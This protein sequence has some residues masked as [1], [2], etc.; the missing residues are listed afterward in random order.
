MFGENSPPLSYTG[1]HAHTCS[2][3]T[4]PPLTILPCTSYHSNGHHHSNLI[5]THTNNLWV[6]IASHSYLLSIRQLAILTPPTT[7]FPN[8]LL[9]IPDAPVTTL[10]SHY[11][12]SGIKANLPVSSVACIENS[13][14]AL[15]ICSPNH[16]QAFCRIKSYFL[17]LTCEE[18][19]SGPC[20]FHICPWPSPQASSVALPPSSL[21]LPRFISLS[22]ISRLF[23]QLKHLFLCLYL[24]VFI[25]FPRHPFLFPWSP[26]SFPQLI[27][28]LS[29]Y[30]HC[31][32]PPQPSPQGSL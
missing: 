6:T 11:L 16:R 14:G 15:P 27:Q 29:S 8:L 31:I 4:T 19:R 21:L 22:Y 23:P 12:F 20:T 5:T 3:L 7:L 2:C 18:L 9:H 25:T 30:A 26:S 32:P 24:L 10:L 13:L 17:S 28:V 1:A